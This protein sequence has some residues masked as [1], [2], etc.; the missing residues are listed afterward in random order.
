MTTLVLTPS[1][2]YYF[3]VVNGYLEFGYDLGSGPAIIH[4]GK[5]RINDGERHSVI[6]KRR[7]KVGSIEIDNTYYEAGEAE[8][9]TNTL[10]TAG[11]IYLGKFLILWLIH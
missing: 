5:I 10:N 7:G 2:I 4:N 6:L 8:G 9:F 1:D 11:N 3:S